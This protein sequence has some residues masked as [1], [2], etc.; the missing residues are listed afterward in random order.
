MNDPERKINRQNGAETETKDAGAGI[1]DAIWNLLAST[2]FAVILLAFIALTALVGAF[3]PQQPSQQLLRELASRWGEGRVAILNALDFFDLYHS[4]WFQGSLAVL[5]ISIFICTFDRLPKTMRLIRK[6]DAVLAGGDPERMRIHHG[7]DLTCKV[8]KT[9]DAVRNWIKKRSLSSK[10]E[11]RGENRWFFI[12]RGARSRLA[13]YV[14]HAS[15]ITVIIGALIGNIA[16]FRG[17]LPLLEG[18]TEDTFFRWGK[19]GGWAP[20]G[21]QI[22]CEAFSFSI[23]PETGMAGNYES[24]LVILNSGK[25]V[26]TIKLRVNHPYYYQ[27]IGFYQS[28]YDLFVD[29]TGEVGIESAVVTVLSPDGAELGALTLPEDGSAIEVPGGGLMRIIRAQ[30]N[31]NTKTITAVTV[32]IDTGESGK[33]VMNL[34]PGQKAVPTAISYAVEVVAR[35]Y[36]DDVEVARISLSAGEEKEIQQGI[37]VKLAAYFPT[38]PVHGKEESAARIFVTADEEK[39]QHMLFESFPDFD[40]MNPQGNLYFSIGKVTQSGDSTKYDGPSYMLEKTD[41]LYWTILDVNRDPGVPVVYTG[42]ALLIIGVFSSFFLSHRKV[43]IKVSPGRVS[44]GAAVNRN[45]ATFEKQF[46]RW[47]SE[48]ERLLSTESRE[49]NDR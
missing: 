8:D 20:L 6:R 26:D 7:F 35:K 33:S 1:V 10:E 16:G 19:F 32:E 5:C 30:V 23:D 13:V 34:R 21:F 36:Q 12:N 48:L 11:T 22:R 17:R 29:K 47:A 2:R 37:T 45:R 38:F 9:T 25:V 31:D 43:W 49:D 44:M 39:R 40:K 28:S 15:I 24:D 18:Q 27:G 42:C 41:G 14:V 46:Q 4:R 3:L